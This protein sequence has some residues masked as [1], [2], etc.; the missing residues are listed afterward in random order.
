MTTTAADTLS[1]GPEL[2]E[3]LVSLR[4]DFHQHPELAH[5]EHRTAGVVADVLREAGL[6]EVRTQVG[7]TG[8]VGVLRGARPGRT[9]LLRADMDALP[10][11]EADRGQP[12]RSRNEGAH[13]ACGHD[14]HLAI[15]LV[16]ARVLAERRAAL[17]GTVLFVFQ[18]AEE[19]VG[20]AAGMI[21]AGALADPPPDA[22][23]GLHLWTNLPA[24]R[25][26]AR[27][28]PVF[29]A[30]DAFTIRLAGRGGHGAMPHQTADPIVCAAHLVVA[31]QTLVSREMDPFEP[32]AL[33]I[34]SI[35]G[36]TAH[37]IIP[38]QVE[39]HG[40]LRTF[41]G[42]TRTRLLDRLA[43]LVRDIARM[44]RLEGEVTVPPGCPACVNDPAMADLVTRVA[45]EV[46]GAEHVSS[47]QRTA[48]ADDMA[49]F[50]DAAPGCYFLLG[51]AD[52]ERG[53]DSPHHSPA[54]D[55]DEAA[56]PIGVRL[57]VGVATRYLSTGSGGG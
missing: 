48:G 10:L 43:D 21:E 54:F 53:L 41:E 56:L 14:G 28:G 9:V 34:G 30:A 46:V 24:G 22:T 4:R 42:A 23:F 27:P 38:A 25:V 3:R 15:L 11:T 32:A 31:L 39:L 47:T 18:P 2:L 17:P 1:L 20:G 8:V 55:F 40:T 12:Y 7:T 5:Q 19:Q 57:L 49:L 16:A 45:A 50:L 44:F 51:A 37:N 52:P 36:G 26:D 13:H 29:A 33:T 35:H 6:D